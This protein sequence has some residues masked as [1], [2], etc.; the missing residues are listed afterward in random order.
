MN[1]RTLS[2]TLALGLLA[3][4][5]ITMGFAT[6]PDDPAPKK[7]LVIGIVAKSQSNPVFQA[8]RT[9]AE[10]ACR[11]LSKKLGI[12]I[13]PNWRTPTNEDAQ[14]QAQFVE[15]LVSQ[16][17]DGIAISCSDAN[18]LTSAIDDAVGKGVQVVTFDSDAPKSKR[19]AY[20]GIDDVEAGREVA[21]YLAKAMGDKGTVAILAGNQ[22]APNL[23]ARV[24]GVKEE[25]ANH[26]DIKIKDVYYHKETANDAAAMVQQ[27]QNA[28]PDISGWAMVGGWP[29][30][31]QNALD[32]IYDKAKVVSVDT[33][34]EQL[35]YVKNGQV[36]TLIGQDCYGW[37][38]QSVVMLVDK[39]NS[40][41]SPEKVINTFKLAVV[42]KDNVKEYEGLW[43]KWL[44][45]K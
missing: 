38:Y 18:L 14:Q 40:D 39:L 22:N 11:D 20:Y 36:D 24:R 15:Q 27:V 34:P 19:M 6:R 10:D 8:A 35:E 4:G 25:L 29:L 41:K 23:Q 26:K 7:S 17:A 2:R 3:A 30:F 32:G 1:R 16:G 45:K 33:L 37:G 5:A 21:R 12:D 44:K 42:N 9:G 28:N 31:T 13:K 43:Q